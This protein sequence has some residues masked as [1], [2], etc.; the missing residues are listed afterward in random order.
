MQQPVDLNQALPRGPRDTTSPVA[1][2]GNLRSLVL[3][4][5][6]SQMSRRQLTA[7]LLGNKTDAGEH[8]TTNDVGLF[9]PPDR[10]AVI[11][12]AYLTASPGSPE[13]RNATL[14]A[15]GEAVAHTLRS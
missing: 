6:L 14:A 8:G 15:V 11:V 12:C 1:M 13:R 2:L 9:W 10:D 4:D 7:W 5:V 3:G